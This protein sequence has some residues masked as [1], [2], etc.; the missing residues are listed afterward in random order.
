M[1]VRQTHYV[2][3]AIKAPMRREDDYEKWEPFED[4]GYVEKITEHEGLTAVS[5]G[6]NG[7]YSMIGIVLAKGLEHEGIDMT[8]CASP[9]PRISA[10]I[11]RDAKRLLGVKGCVA[12]YAFTHFH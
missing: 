12:V 1:G 3:L 7:N 5:D 6:M 4:N 8:E 10:R 11:E 2:M 9:D